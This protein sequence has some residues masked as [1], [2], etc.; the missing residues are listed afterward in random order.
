MDGSLVFCARTKLAVCAPLDFTTSTTTTT[1]TTTTKV[2]T[3]TTTTTTTTMTTTTSSPTATTTT[4]IDQAGLRAAPEAGD[5]NPRFGVGV[6]IIAVG[7]LGV[8]FFGF[9]LTRLQRVSPS[10]CSAETFELIESH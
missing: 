8:G 10:R 4:T 2:A 1:T 7:F 3:T 6:L 5:R 9:F